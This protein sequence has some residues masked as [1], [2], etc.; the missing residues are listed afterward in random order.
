MFLQEPLLKAVQYLP[1]IVVLQRQLY[2]MCNHRLDLSDAETITMRAFLTTAGSQQTS[3]TMITHVSRFVSCLCYYV[4]A[5]TFESNE[6]NIIFYNVD[7]ISLDGKFYASGLLF[8]IIQH[9]FTGLH[10]LTVVLKNSN[11]ACICAGYQASKLSDV[12]FCHSTHNE[13]T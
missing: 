6:Q 11:A 5:E 8:G 3:K 1:D 2:D 9:T 7:A 13:Y 4:P 12:A 10:T